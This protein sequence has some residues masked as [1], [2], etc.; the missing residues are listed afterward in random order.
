V[1]DVTLAHTQ[2]EQRHLAAFFEVTAPSLRPAQHDLGPGA[3]AGE[4]GGISS[5]G[6]GEERGIGGGLM[7]RDGGGKRRTHARVRGSAVRLQR[8]G[9]HRGRGRE[10]GGGAQERQRRAGANV[11]GA[12]FAVENEAGIA[13]GDQTVGGEVP[14]ECGVG[15]GED[16]RVRGHQE[17]EGG[18]KGKEVVAQQE[19][20]TVK[21]PDKDKA[22]E[23]KDE[24]R[25]LGS[26]VSSD[27]SHPPATSATAADA[28]LAYATPETGAASCAAYSRMPHTLVVLPALSAKARQR[29]HSLCDELGLW[30]RAIHG[31]KGRGRGDCSFLVGGG[32]MVY[33]E[34]LA[35]GALGAGFAL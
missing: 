15:C 31:S 6:G 11:F 3:A 35:D 34:T 28:A 9:R 16:L 25:S 29:A 32:D 33:V 1:W 7:D 18:E 23:K 13:V 26:C 30:H 20:E 14:R 2:Y 8:H 17:R 4:G 27:N 21:V 22:E 5:S 24:C 19:E 12:L 10:G